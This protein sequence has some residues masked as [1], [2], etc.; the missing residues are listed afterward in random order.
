MN[1]DIKLV[2]SLKVG[3]FMQVSDAEVLACVKWHTCHK[4]Y[5]NFQEYCDNIKCDL[6]HRPVLMYILKKQ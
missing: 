3:E 5:F 2:N 6:S 4:C 1:I